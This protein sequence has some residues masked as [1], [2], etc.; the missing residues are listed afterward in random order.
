MENYPEAEW[1]NMVKRVNKLAR[2][3]AA[4]KLLEL[5]DFETAKREIGRIVSGYESEYL[6]LGKDMEKI[7]AIREK[8]N[9]VYYAL[10]HPLL[11]MDSMSLL[12][13]R[14]WK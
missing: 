7:A 8:Y 6:Y 5:A 9:A 10:T 4:K 14:R 13:L 11:T 1:T 2:D 3:K 12:Y